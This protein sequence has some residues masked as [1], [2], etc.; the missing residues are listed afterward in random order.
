MAQERKFWDPIVETMPLDKLRKLQ[1]ERLQEAV[2]HAYEKSALYRRKFDAVGIKPSDI[3][4]VEDIA[5]LP[6]TEDA[7]IRGTPFSEKLAI[8]L[9]QVKMFHSTSGTTTGVPEPVPFN[10]KSMDTFF[11]LESR[12]RWTMGVRPWDVVQVL[13]QFDCCF[14]GY[15]NLGATVVMLS[16]G[17]YRLDG[18]IRLTQSAG[19]TVLEHAPS[20]LLKYFERAQEL[21][22][23][24]KKTKVRMVSG[25]GEGWAESYKRKVEAQYG[26]PFMT[27]WGSVELGV[28]S[29][30]CEARGGMHIFSD[31]FLIE[32]IDP[33]TLKP[34]PPGEEGE[35]VLTPLWCEAMPLIRYRIGD[36]AKILPYE[37][38]PCGRTSPKMS[39]VKG[40]ISHI[41][42][43]KGVKIM[44][45]DVE[46]IA[47]SIEGL[48][49]NYQIVVDKPGELERLKV[50]MEYKPEVSNLSALGN[51]AEEAFN[52]NLGIDAEIEL[53]PIGSIVS[54]TFKAQRVVTT[55][56]KA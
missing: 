52:R 13:T 40:R 29:A 43:V 41:V 53:L 56:D 28:A 49:E 15:K 6:L 30:E 46:E 37:P 45:I 55:Y 32:V 18:Q 26:F 10:Q 24:I 2:T 36:V 31:L 33:E 23:D 16:A 12:G 7:E 27:L 21:G 3:K 19:V 48:A 42:K 1:G 8:P 22:I 9:E 11:Y 17:R 54:T 20:L 4:G 47:A 44:P 5:K 39:M 35:I 14:F 25:V 34:L 51:Q 50:K 38:C